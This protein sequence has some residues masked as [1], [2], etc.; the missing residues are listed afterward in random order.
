MAVLNLI[1]VIMINP[2][3]LT[4]SNTPS[5]CQAGLRTRAVPDTCACNQL[6]CLPEITFLG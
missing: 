4:D 5:I 3:A 2:E 1:R 6:S